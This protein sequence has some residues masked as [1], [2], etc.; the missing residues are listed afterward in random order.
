MLIVRLP[1]AL[2][3]DEEADDWMFGALLMDCMAQPD[4]CD[5]NARAPRLDIMQ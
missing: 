3:T 4:G 1:R 2:T 5:C